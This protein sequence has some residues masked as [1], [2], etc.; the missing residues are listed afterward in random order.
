MRKERPA[1]CSRPKFIHGRRTGLTAFAIAAALAVLGPPAAAQA[2]S[3]QL[4]V[5]AM[6]YN[7][8]QGSELTDAIAAA[9]PAQLLAAV[10]TDYGQVQATNFPDR[11]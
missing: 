6:T 2:G 5:K 10:A 11:A 7:L 4:Q 9:A 1:D 8:F 3:G